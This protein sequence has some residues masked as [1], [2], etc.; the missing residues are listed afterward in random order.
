MNEKSLT[1]SPHKYCIKRI[2]MKIELQ[3][4]YLKNWFLIWE[5]VYNMEQRVLKKVMENVYYEKTTQKPQN[6]G[7][8]E[9]IH[10]TRSSVRQLE[11]KD[12]TLKRVPLMATWIL[13]NLKQEQ[14]LKL[15][16][17]MVTSLTL[18]K[19]LWEKLSKEISSLQINNLC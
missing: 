13:L 17:I 12:F 15:S 4:F 5:T 7:T 18:K 2:E 8:K 14:T 1:P 3:W 19:C 6:F 16:G 9:I 11:G 10:W